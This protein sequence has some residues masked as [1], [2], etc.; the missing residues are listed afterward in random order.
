MKIMQSISFNKNKKVLLQR[1]QFRKWKT[2]KISKLIL[3]MHRTES[4]L[5]PYSNSEYNK[6][7]HRNIFS[8]LFYRAQNVFYKNQHYP[9]TK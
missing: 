9:K 3:Q 6:I 2:R 8:P 4:R 1:H 5:S 7:F